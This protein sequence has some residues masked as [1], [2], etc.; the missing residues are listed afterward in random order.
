M[1][2]YLRGGGVPDKAVGFELLDP[3]PYAFHINWMLQMLRYLRGG[4]GT[5]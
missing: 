4:G 3:R 5:R 1:L 2:R